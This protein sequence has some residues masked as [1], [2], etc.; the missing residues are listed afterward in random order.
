MARKWEIPPDALRGS[1]FDRGYA[2]WQPHVWED[3]DG[4]SICIQSIETKDQ[5]Q[6]TLQRDEAEDLIGLLLKLMA[7]PKPEWED[8]EEAI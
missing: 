8:E 7:Q 5:R 6:F 3:P 4:I 2:V 1:R